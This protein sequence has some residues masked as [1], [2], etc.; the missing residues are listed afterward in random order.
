VRTHY[1]PRSR[2]SRRT[3]QNA[4]R[5][6]SNLRRRSL[7]QRGLHTVARLQTAD[8]PATVA[9]D[10]C[11]PSSRRNMR[12]RR[13]MTEHFRTRTCLPPCDAEPLARCGAPN[14]AW[15]AASS[16]RRS[17][18]KC[19]LRRALL[20]LRF[21]CNSLYVCS[22]V[23]H[24]MDSEASCGCA[25]AISHIELSYWYTCIIIANTTHKI[26]ASD[27]ASHVSSACFHI[28]HTTPK[29]AYSV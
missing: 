28:P 26:A 6:C 25:Q 7:R 12:K 14:S 5:S 18:N 9:R 23:I 17:Q 4:R 10:K 11:K 22:V 16:R 8:A 19:A 13:A 21:G 1:L 2:R 15:P 20:G 29:R 24:I 27:H 3:S